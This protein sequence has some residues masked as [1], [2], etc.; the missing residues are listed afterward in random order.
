MEEMAPRG[1]VLNPAH[2]GL[3]GGTSQQ[4]YQGEVWGDWQPSADKSDVVLLN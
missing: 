2:C 4:Q 3:S 1:L